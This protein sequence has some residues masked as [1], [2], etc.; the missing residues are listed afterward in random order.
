MI[1]KSFDP[2]RA[3]LFR[4]ADLERVSERTADLLARVKFACQEQKQFVAQ[5]VADALRRDAERRLNPGSPWG[6]EEYESAFYKALIVEA[7]GL[8]QMT[9]PIDH[10]E[11]AAM[12]A[13]LTGGQERSPAIPLPT[14]T[15]TLDEA[16]ALAGVRLTRAFTKLDDWQAERWREREALRLSSE[17]GEEGSG[18][19]GSSGQ[20]LAASVWLILDAVKS[21]LHGRPIP[22]DDWRR[23]M[24]RC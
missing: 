7:R 22:D 17:T 5:I 24:G 19:S 16:T 14:A 3:K 1:W 8:F 10:V 9:R 15:I 20:S 2:E 4:D 13:Q 21:E 12:L 23:L 6:H 11:T 18:C